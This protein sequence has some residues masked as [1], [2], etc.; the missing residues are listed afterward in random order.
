MRERERERER[1]GGLG[2]LLKEQ[3]FLDNFKTAEC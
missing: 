2:K 3:K 1:W